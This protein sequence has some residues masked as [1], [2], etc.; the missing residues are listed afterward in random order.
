MDEEG[1]GVV[2]RIAD[3]FAS[4][5]ADGREIE[6]DCCTVRLL[7]HSGRYTAEHSPAARVKAGPNQQ[8][9]PRSDRSHS[10]RRRY[11]FPLVESYAAT[12]RRLADCW[13]SVDPQG[14]KAAAANLRTQPAPT[15]V[16]GDINSEARAFATVI[17]ADSAERPSGIITQVRPIPVPSNLP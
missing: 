15:Y 9:I 11:A 7:D 2:A 3:F 6:G 12:R 16:G 5:A 1:S 8:I 13:L 17:D 4:C 14:F 10:F